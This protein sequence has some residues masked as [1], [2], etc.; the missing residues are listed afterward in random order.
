MVFIFLII[1]LLS[2]HFILSE[3]SNPTRSTIRISGGSLLNQKCFRIALPSAPMRSLGWLM[4]CSNTLGRPLIA[5]STLPSVHLQIVQL[6]LANVWIADSAA[7]DLTRSIT[8]RS[9]ASWIFV[10][11][12][13][14]IDNVGTHLISLRSNCANSTAFSSSLNS[15]NPSDSLLTSIGVD[16]VANSNLF[17][18]TGCSWSIGRSRIPQQLLQLGVFGI[19]AWKVDIC[20]LLSCICSTD[21]LDTH[22]GSS[23]C[24]SISLII[25]NQRTNYIC[26]LLVCQPWLPTRNRLLVLRLLLLVGKEIVYLTPS[27][28]AV[29]AD[30]P[31]HVMVRLQIYFWVFC[32]QHMVMVTPHKIVAVGLSI[33][34]LSLL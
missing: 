24:T 14:C 25:W 33:V 21:R 28:V 32:S 4:A 26:I 11:C 17:S 3:S 9:R 15:S 19:V 20:V 18:A 6:D 22:S 7:N 10:S 30:W 13:D 31:R 27:H 2:N 34:T 1:I 5:S 23:S 12:R 29:T 16:Q 8:G